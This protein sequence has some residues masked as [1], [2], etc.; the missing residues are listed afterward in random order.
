MNSQIASGLMEMM[1]ML[2]LMVAF[3]V[4]LAWLAKKTKGFGFQGNKQ[5]QIV[6]TLPLGPKERAVL[7]ELKGT[8]MLLGVTAQ[9]VNILWQSTR[10]PQNEFE[11]AGVDSPKMESQILNPLIM[12]VSEMSNEQNYFATY[13]NKILKRKIAC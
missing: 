7:I 11:P 13:L 5:L 10:L 8:H 2:V 9:Q 6:Q 12:N 4:W 3:I 1:L